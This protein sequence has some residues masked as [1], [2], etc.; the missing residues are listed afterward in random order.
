MMGQDP[1]AVANRDAL[2]DPQI[3]DWYVDYAAA[4]RDPS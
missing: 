2:Q 4:H 1:G 3:L